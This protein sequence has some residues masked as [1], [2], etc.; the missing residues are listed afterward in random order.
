MTSSEADAI[1]GPLVEDL[2]PE[3][4][5]R[6]LAQLAHRAAARLHTLSR[7][8]AAARKDQ[9]DWAQWAQVQNAARALILQA[10]TCRDLASRLARDSD[11]GSAGKSGGG[12]AS[13]AG[14]ASEAGTERRSGDASESGNQ[15]KS[16]TERDAGGGGAGRSRE[17]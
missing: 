1:L 15:G 13:D 14:T 12:T 9:A 6:V 10:S 5:A 16:G 3:E 17:P 11:S 8:Q 7:G 2:P 4:A